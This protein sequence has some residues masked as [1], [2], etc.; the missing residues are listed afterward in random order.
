M[1]T[2]PKGLG[3]LLQVAFKAAVDVSGD[4]DPNAIHALTQRYFNVL[5]DLGEKNSVEFTGPKSGGGGGW[6][7][8]GG[9][10]STSK[11]ANLP[12]VNVDFFGDGNAI[13]FYDQRSLKASGDYKPNAPDF[14][15]VDKF[16]GLGRDG[17][18]GSA[19]IWITK[20]GVLNE[21]EARMLTAAGVDLTLPNSPQDL[22]NQATAPAAPIPTVET[23]GF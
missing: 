8:G 14:S 21:N 22:A 12:K 16:D 11:R 6:K 23:A 17:E 15:S 19:A 13:S 3:I 4:P 10:Q 2:D 7:G 20:D 18:K 1:K 9:G 5:L